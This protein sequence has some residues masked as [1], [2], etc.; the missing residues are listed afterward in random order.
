MSD[1]PSKEIPTS[2][3][4]YQLFPRQL[5][6]ED[7]PEP[8]VMS[9]L[10]PSLPAGYRSLGQIIAATASMGVSAP[11]TRPFVPSFGMS[12]Q[13]PITSSPQV[14]SIPVRPTVCV[15]ASTTA[16]TTQSVRTTSLP[17]DV[18]IASTM[19]KNISPEEYRLSLQQSNPEVGQSSQDPNRPYF[20]HYA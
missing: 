17:E 7:N 6:P 14:T 19:S 16:V 18:Y 1:S 11:S 15:A 5:F 12:P 13:T 10:G 4:D 2:G 9:S 3:E 20:S 8:S